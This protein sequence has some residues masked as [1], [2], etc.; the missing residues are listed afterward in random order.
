M[1]TFFKRLITLLIIAGSSSVQAD[2]LQKLPPIFWPEDQLIPIQLANTTTMADGLEFNIT[3]FKNPAVPLY[4]YSMSQWQVVPQLNF[5]K[6]SLS[7]ANKRNGAIKAGL[8]I[9]QSNHWLKNLDTET[10]NRYVAGLQNRNRERF[11]W[12]NPDTG[13]APIPGTGFFAGNPYKIVHY[14]IRPEE[15]NQPTVE[16]WDFIADSDG[17]LLIL[18]FECPQ[19]LASHNSGTPLNLMSSIGRVDELE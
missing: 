3:K 9:V 11:T 17:H 6:A 15:D 7:F 18:S 19:E 8:S 1:H 13:F 5:R 2:T 14:R 10:L 16:V 4:S 12:L